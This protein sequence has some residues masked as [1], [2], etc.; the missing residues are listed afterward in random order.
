MIYAVNVIVQA[1]LLD[2]NDRYVAVHGPVV[3]IVEGLDL[4]RQGAWF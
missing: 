3:G 2:Q 4:A 1:V